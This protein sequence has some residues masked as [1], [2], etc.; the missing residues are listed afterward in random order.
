M[1]AGDSSS[2]NRLYLNN[3]TASPFDGVTGQNTSGD[4]AQTRS[5]A[6][7]DINNDGLLDMVAGNIGINRVYYN[8]GT[9]T[10]Y[11]AGEN[12]S[13]DSQTT[14]AVVLADMDSDGDLDLVA[15]NNGL[16]KL[17]INAGSPT[18]LTG[19]TSQDVSDDSDAT[20]AISVVDLNNDGHLD[21][22]AANFQ[23]GDRYYLNNGTAAPFNGVAGK[24]L[25]D[26]TSYSESIA[27]GDLD[28]DGY[29]EILI[30]NNSQIDRIYSRKLYNTAGGS[31]SSLRVDT[32]TANIDAVK[33]TVAATTPAHSLV[34]YRL[35]ND[36]GNKFYLVKPDQLFIFPTAGTD[37]R[38]R[39]DMKSLSPAISPKID[40]L[41][42]Q[43]FDIPVIT[44]Q[45][46]LQIAENTSHVL[47]FQNI[48][49]TD[50]DSAYPGDF[51]LVAADGANYARSGNTITP[52]TDYV[53]SI[54]VPVYINDGALDSNVF[55]VT[56]TV[57]AD[58]DGDGTPNVDD[59]FPT[60]AN[61]TVDTDGDGT[62]NNADTDD[63]GDGIPD[64]VEILAGLDPLNAADAALDLDGDGIS[65]L[66]EYKAG[67]NISDTPADTE[68]D[69]QTGSLTAPVLVAPADKDAEVDPN[70]ATFSWRA[71]S[72]AEGEV[73]SYSL[74]ICENSDFSGCDTP[75]T[76]AKLTPLN[77]LSGLG[78]SGIVVLGLF[79]ING[80]R[81]RD[82]LTVLAMVLIFA[83]LSACGKSEDKTPEL[84]D[85]IVKHTVTDLLPETKYFWK[86]V[87][88]GTESGSVESSVRSFTTR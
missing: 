72:G 83:S 28:G 57:L 61:E 79:G 23:Q 26:E 11:T 84:A 49:V 15:G 64:N 14:R 8:S 25:S 6:L 65:N 17:Y 13:G 67:T 74:E 62:G 78:G 16:I 46:S 7:G 87:A 41:S 39:V 27:A 53:G 56:I 29:V 31:A 51:T 20:K 9:S 52:T 42:L 33:L 55:D 43:A 82:L 80:A 22:V 19:A 18:Y 37:L 44:G 3:G 70:N 4:S 45:S 54:T 47:S 58:D 75:V 48:T 81:R 77:I 88:T 59:A 2:A 38:W 32:E 76:V 12:V 10:P 34:D 69:P 36:G 86:V 85:D 35:S 66:D 73:I 71:V 30:G 50:S 1:V 21:I 24:N 68:K 40:N 60:D 63:D 5:V